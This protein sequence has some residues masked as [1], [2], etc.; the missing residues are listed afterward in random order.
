MIDH[1]PGGALS[2]LAMKLDAEEG[3]LFGKPCL[4]I[5]GKAFVAAFK[6]S[7]VF[8]LAADDREKALSLRGSALWDPSGKKRPMKEWV[9]VTPAHESK[10]LALARRARSFVSGT[11]V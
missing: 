9:V 1:D 7:V 2:K 8:K 4:K 5:A 11:A 10:W 6:G 3:V